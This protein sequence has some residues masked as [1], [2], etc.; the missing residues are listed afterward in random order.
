MSDVEQ[1]V[2]TVLNVLGIFFSTKPW[3]IAL[4]SIVVVAIVTMEVAAANGS[5]E[6]QNKKAEALKQIDQS[7]EQ[8]GIYNMIN[9]DLVMTFA[10]PVID[11][12]IWALN[13][14]VP[15]W[16]QQLTAP[17]APAATAASK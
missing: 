3:F 7:C 14:F 13:T 15:G 10:G 1:T 4:K 8:L 9:K 6:K 11:V 16:N 5:V 12:A 2:S 17:A